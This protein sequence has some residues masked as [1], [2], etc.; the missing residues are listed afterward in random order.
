MS[1]TTAP[2]QV[3]AVVL[4]PESADAPGVL[5]LNG[6]YYD[7]GS[8]PGGFWLHRLATGAVYHARVEDGGCVACDCPAAK[9]TRHRGACKHAHGVE[10]I[11]AAW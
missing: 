11:L 4:R 6:A 10:A 9:Y 5:R 2:R 3:E 8:E 1:T 7:Y